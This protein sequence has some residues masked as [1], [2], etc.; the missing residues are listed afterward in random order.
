MLQ[1]ENVPSAPVD[2]LTAAP[3]LPEDTLLHRSLTP[4]KIDPESLA[5]SMRI[6]LER[7]R[8]RMKESYRITADQM[9]DLT[10]QLTGLGEDLDA[11]SP[12]DRFQEESG[13]FQAL[14]RHVQEQKQIAETMADH[15]Q[16][17]WD[18]AAESWR[19]KMEPLLV[20]NAPQWY[21]DVSREMD[22]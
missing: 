8:D 3:P 18:S 19:A 22:S 6:T 14:R 7:V 13:G 15:L 20:K 9:K 4:E 1:A 2:K 21:V 10:V 16:K 5:Q 11:L 12:E 17:H